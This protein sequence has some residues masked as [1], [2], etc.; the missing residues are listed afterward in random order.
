M[1]LHEKRTLTAHSRQ[2]LF[3]PSGVRYILVSSVILSLMTGE[4]EVPLQQ[5]PFFSSYIVHTQAGM[6]CESV[7][8][9]TWMLCVSVA[10]KLPCDSQEQVI[11][12]ECLC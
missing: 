4:S 12:L 7:T 9:V 11:G 6:M 3:R 10:L 1:S 5:V 2:L 8:M